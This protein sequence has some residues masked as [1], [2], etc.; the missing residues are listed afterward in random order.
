MNSWIIEVGSGIFLSSLDQPFLEGE[1][2]LHNKPYLKAIISATEKLKFF[3][4][5]F[6]SIDGIHKPEKARTESKLE[7][8]SSARSIRAVGIVTQIGAYF[9]LAS[10]V[11]RLGSSSA[12]ATL[13]MEQA[14]AA[15][16]ANIKSLLPL[17]LSSLFFTSTLTPSVVLEALATMSPLRGVVVEG[18]LA[19][20]EPA[21]NE[22]VMVMDAISAA[23]QVFCSSLS[24]GWETII[25]FLIPENVLTNGLMPRIVLSLLEF[26]VTKLRDQYGHQWASL[27]LKT[28]KDTSIALLVNCYP[29]QRLRL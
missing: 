6:A 11:P 20:A 25:H 15:A 26:V 9:F 18:C 24:L 13:A 12:M 22:A 19:M 21:R 8:K 17:L 2:N 23:L 3:C 7:E 28:W 16:A 5:N 10:G 29:G 4:D 27:E 14:A 1:V